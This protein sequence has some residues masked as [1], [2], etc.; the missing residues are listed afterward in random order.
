MRFYLN[1]SEQLSQIWLDK[2]V[3]VLVLLIVKVYLFK[4]ALIAGITNCQLQADQAC[5]S[6][7]ELSRQAG[8]LPHAISQMTNYVIQQCINNLKGQ[9]QM[10]LRLALAILKALIGF[11]IEVYLGTFTCLCTAFVKGTIEILT[12]AV[13]TVTE[14]VEQVVNEFLKGFNS[15]L[16]GLST[17]VNGFVTTLKGIKSFFTDADTSDLSSAVETVNL[18]AST[19]KNITIPTSFIDDLSD[20]SNKIPDYEEVLSNLTAV[21]TRPIDILRKEVDALTS[22]NATLDFAEIDAYQR[23]TTSSTCD[24]LD[25]EFISMKSSVASTCSWIILGL[26]LSILFVIMALVFLAHRSHRR[27]VRYIEELTLENSPDRIGNVLEIQRN[28]FGMIL[29][30]LDINYRVKWLLNYLSSPSAVNCLLLGLA[31]L[32]IVGLQYWLLLIT[33]NRLNAMFDHESTPVHNGT[34]QRNVDAY[35][36]ETQFALDNSSE[37]LNDA[38]FGSIART[39]ESLYDNLIDAERSINDTI[40]SVFGGTPFASPLHTIVYCTIGRKLEKVEDG[41]QW[42]NRNLKIEYPTLPEE[43]MRSLMT[44]TLNDAT[45][46]QIAIHRTS[47]ILCLSWYMAPTIDYWAPNSSIPGVRGQKSAPEGNQYAKTA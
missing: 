8:S 43:K 32:L 13:R 25:N 29:M 2:Y 33:S 24:K 22:N 11:V 6:M 26:G 23:S 4:N 44:D 7:D 17:V 20:L 39:S 41:L 30:N 47:C 14:G 15:A 10:V 35:I 12:D 5:Q 38:L 46:D 9:L 31:G 16:D 21:V 19:I 40:N 27:R 42:V 36:S 45:N 1:F 3:I 18:T 34:M 37:S 28:R